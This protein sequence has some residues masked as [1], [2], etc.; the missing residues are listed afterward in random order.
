MRRALK[1][2]AGFG[3]DVK[4]VSFGQPS[5]RISALARDFSRSVNGFI[6]VRLLKLTIR[7]GLESRSRVAD[8]CWKS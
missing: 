7:C 1:L 5:R 6:A 4:I 8:F 2:S 3:L